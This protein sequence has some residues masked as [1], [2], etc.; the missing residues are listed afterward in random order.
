[1][2]FEEARGMKVTHS[3][4]LFLSIVLAAGAQG[5][6]CSRPDVPTTGQVSSFGACD[7]CSAVAQLPR[8]RL[9]PTPGVPLPPGGASPGTEPSG[10]PRVRLL[11]PETPPSDTGGG[12]GNPPSVGESARPTQPP[13]S[14]EPP[15]LNADVPG[16]AV[17]KPQ[18]ASG[19]KPFADGLNWLKEKGYRTVLHVRPPGEDDSAI[20]RQ[21]E[22]KGFRY[23]S[24]EV[25]PQ[26]LT[27]EVVDRFNRTVNDTNNL[28]LYVFDRDSALVGGLWFLHF[29]IIDGLANEKATAEAARLGLNPDADAGPHREMWLAVQKYLQ[30]S[31][32]K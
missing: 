13:S 9:T 23:L 14:E 25:S 15:A 29:R 32:P 24:L 3:R 1:M 8:G 7:S 22:A 16:F 2:S 26:A 6:A 19:Q 18:V 21:F 30:M 31:K 4:L 17:V 27:P 28:P 12:V 10:P 5:C 20:R 11:V